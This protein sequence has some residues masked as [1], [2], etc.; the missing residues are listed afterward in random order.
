MTPPSEPVGSPAQTGPFLYTFTFRLPYVLGIRSGFEV[1]INTAPY[2]SASHVD[3]FARSPFVRIRFLNQHIADYKFLPANLSS[4][5]VTFYGGDVPDIEAGKGIQ[6]YEQ[7]VSIE[8]PAVLLVNENPAEGA[9]AFHRGL[10]FLNLFLAAYGLARQDNAMRPISSRELRPVIMTGHL[11]L[12]GVWKE[13]GL[14]LMHPDAKERIPL[15][16]KTIEE[17]LGD[18]TE[19]IVHSKPFVNTLQWQA[20]AERRKYEGDSG[21]SIVSFQVAAETLLYELWTLLLRDEGVAEA[22]IETRRA[23]LPFASLL[24]RELAQRLGGSWDLTDVGRPMGDYWANLY[25]LRNRITHGGY[26]PHD[27]DAGAA[28]RAF[29]VLDG[30]LNDRLKVAEKKYPGAWA[31]KLKASYLQPPVPESELSD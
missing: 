26:L 9:Y 16:I 21:D 11:D 10:Q 14:M 25:L 29:A 6:L 13:Q 5:L 8:T 7:W 28:E 30:F 19:A 18:A 3:T 12:E 17:R 15:S 22:E 23:E 4:A 27:G 20:R 31:A 24:K 1:T 2:A